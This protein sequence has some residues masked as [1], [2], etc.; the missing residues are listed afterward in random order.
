M[1]DFLLLV[2][3][4]GFFL[5]LVTGYYR[6]LWNGQIKRKGLLLGATVFFWT[7]LNLCCY[8][9]DERY[10]IR[11]K[12]AFA[13]IVV[14]MTGGVILYYVLSYG[15]ERQ[16][17]LRERLAQQPLE[18]LQM[19]Y[20]LITQQQMELGRQR[21]E[22]KNLYLSIE[23]MAEK[24][25]TAGILELVRQK[26]ALLAEG[27][28]RAA[29]G[30]RVVDA[31]LNYRIEREE[32]QEISYELKLNIPTTLNLSDVILSGVLGNLL[33]NAIEASLYL[34]R[35]A[36]QV[37]VS[38]YIDRKNLFLEVINNFDGTI[39]TDGKG[40][41]VTRK[42]D[43]TGHGYGLSVIQDLLDAKDGNIQLLWS[44]RQFQARV[45]FYHVV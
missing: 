16:R 25:D 40:Q 15:L 26:G 3:I 9:V 13:A 20:E 41:L 12:L 33:D 42:K 21:H 30:N 17:N 24:Q 45:V 36:R 28:G 18:G 19:Q 43:K 7:L 8:L 14:M 35:E 29:T 23:S 44:D 5:Y 38:M 1:T 22:L 31:V 39:R 11:G 2:V 37:I 27:K 6:L 10:P 4:N 34:P 32:V